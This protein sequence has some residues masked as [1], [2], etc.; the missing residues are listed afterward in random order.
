MTD[1]LEAAADHVPT[2]RCPRCSGRGHT[3]GYGCGPGVHMV[4]VRGDCRACEG[5]GKVSR[6]RLRDIQDGARARYDRVHSAYRSLNDEARELGIT[7]QEL[8]D[9]ENYGIRWTSTT[10]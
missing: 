9:F 4:E 2:E 5:R 1:L 10:R 6:A 7:P 8:S 3:H